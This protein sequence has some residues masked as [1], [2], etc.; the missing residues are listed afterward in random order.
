MNDLGLSKHLN[1]FSNNILMICSRN[2]TILQNEELVSI[3]VYIRNWMLF[4]KG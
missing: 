3:A 1:N 2:V 4:G